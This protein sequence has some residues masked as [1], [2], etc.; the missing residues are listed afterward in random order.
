MGVLIRAFTVYLKFKMSNH[1]IVFPSLVVVIL[2]CSC[3]LLT[4]QH[5]ISHF[6]NEI[7]GRIITTRDRN[8]IL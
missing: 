8:T 4:R 6:L 7:P 5:E 2:T 3:V 1:N